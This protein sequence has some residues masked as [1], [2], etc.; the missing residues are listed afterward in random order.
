MFLEIYFL[1]RKLK[2]CFI[3]GLSNK[4]ACESSGIVTRTLYD[5]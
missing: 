4:Y 3:E 5:Y 2:R 1:L